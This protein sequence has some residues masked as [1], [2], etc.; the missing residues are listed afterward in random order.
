MTCD[1]LNEIELMAVTGV[2]NQTGSPAAI[3]W[4]STDSSG[5]QRDPGCLPGVLCALA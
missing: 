5:M 2:A 3:R 4:R 1:V